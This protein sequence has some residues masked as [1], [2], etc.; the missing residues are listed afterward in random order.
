MATVTG[1]GLGGVSGLRSLSGTNRYH[2][3]NIDQSNLRPALSSLVTPAKQLR[4][5]TCSA[6]QY[7]GVES[8]SQKASLT[9][10]TFIFILGRGASQVRHPAAAW[11][12]YV[13]TSE[14]SRAHLQ[15]SR[16][17]ASSHACPPAPPT[18]QPVP[19]PSRRQTATRAVFSSMGCGAATCEKVYSCRQAR[20]GRKGKEYVRALQETSGKRGEQYC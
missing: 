11:S 12:C 2:T 10:F 19:L 8:R 17:R 13:F 9:N 20:T 3:R 18:L 14:G 6:Q 7:T 16:G 1:T 5:N 15:Q 4:K